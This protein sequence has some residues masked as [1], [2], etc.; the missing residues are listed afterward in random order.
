MRYVPSEMPLPEVK[1]T[2]ELPAITAVRPA[3]P[4]SERSIPPFPYRPSR[5][6][7]Q[8]ARPD[9][10]SPG[11][12]A[13]KRAED[14]RKTCRRLSRG[15]SLFDSRAGVDRRGSGRRGQDQAVGA[16]DVKA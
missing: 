5:Q 10:R 1:D 12:V 9:I 7:L 16:V 11:A 14:R 13:D 3:R 8:A 6:G 2:G 4:V 15:A